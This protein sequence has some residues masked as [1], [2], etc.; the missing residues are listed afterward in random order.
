MSTVMVAGDELIDQGA[1]ADPCLT[2]HEDDTATGRFE[3][4][5]DVT[6]L[7]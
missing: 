6:K 5:Q 4:V 3:V 7:R 2:A 1:L